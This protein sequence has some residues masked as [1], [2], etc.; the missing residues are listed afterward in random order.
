MAGGGRC[1][2]FI[3][4][5]PRGSAP[6]V[7]LIP[8][9]Y[10][11]TPA[12]ESM[13]QDLA[14]ER[15]VVVMPDLF[16]RTLPGPLGYDGSDREK[17]QERYKKFD[18]AAGVSDLAEVIRWCAR[19]ESSNGKV[20]VMGLCF[21]GRYAVLAAAELGAHAAVSFHGT[22]IGAH[23]D[24]LRRIACPTSLHFGE[25]DPHAPM[26]EVKQ[27]ADASTGNPDIAIFTYPDAP[28]G[29]MQQD[30]PSYRP[31]AARPAWARALDTL[32]K[33]LA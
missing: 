19:E 20:A 16:W 1:D 27:I 5:P 17:A 15:Y 25:S 12:M 18:V 3:A 2:A 6:A 21:G 14:G 7:V 10:G 29:F 13:A 22:Y 9:I 31:D 24:A 32:R 26:T 8:P 28:H 11:A 33:G 23:L 4:R 30:R